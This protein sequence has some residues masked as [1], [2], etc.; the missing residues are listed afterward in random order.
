MVGFIGLVG[1]VHVRAFVVGLWATRPI[2]E[3]L[4]PLLQACSK[5]ENPKICVILLMGLWV[6]WAHLYGFGTF[7][8]GFVPNRTQGI[9][10]S[11]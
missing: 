5:K 2:D 3:L 4:R 7:A 10:L 8:L 1:R 9:V 6:L 11:F